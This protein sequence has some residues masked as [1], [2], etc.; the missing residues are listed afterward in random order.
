MY[1]L[2][3]VEDEFLIQYRIKNTIAWNT[4][5]F[6]VCATASDGQEAL[7][8]IK[9]R[10]PDV[11]VVLTDIK[12]PVMDGIEL[13]KVLKQNYPAVRVIILS[14]YSDFEYAQKAI[15][16]SAYSYVLK[17]IKEDEISALFS[18]LFSELEAS[19]T[20]AQAVSAPNSLRLDDSF[21]YMEPLLLK[22]LKS[23]GSVDEIRKKISGLEYPLHENSFC[24]LSFSCISGSG[25]ASHPPR[26]E[27][28]FSRA[29]YFWA[30]YSAPV[31]QNND[32]FHV[33][34][35]SDKTLYMNEIALRAKKFKA[36]MEREEGAGSSPDGIMVIGIGNVHTSLENMA[37]AC[38]E[39]VTA[40][41]YTFFK[42][43]GVI[44]QY[45]DIPQNKNLRPDSPELKESQ[46]RLFSAI[47][48]GE[49]VN[50]IPCVKKLFSS[51]LALG[52]TDANAF[53]MKCVSIYL[54]FSVKIEERNLPITFLTVDEIYNTLFQCKTLE[55]LTACYQERIY[56]L[57]LQ[58]DKLKS[59]EGNSVIIKIKQYIE[60]S[61]NKK[62]SLKELSEHFS[63]NA[64]YLS[65][66]FKDKTGEN[67][68]D[69]LL[70]VR[71]EKAKGL[72]KKTDKQIVEISEC[73][74]FTDYRYFCT[75]FKKVTGLTPLQYRLNS[76][77]Q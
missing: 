46:D 39:S 32:V 31:L 21:E 56:A 20:S 10:Y 27:S 55:E 50:V 41:N 40:L 75:I 54:Y 38:R 65:T 72:L 6:E 66:L 4:L 37:A 63:L 71:I 51:L 68:T 7:S 64:S 60:D 8:V 26:H 48:A 73:I 34:L 24:I 58:A 1:K 35:H 13:L 23:N 33:I 57:A 47:T 12:M 74:G 3:I 49:P 15:E 53:I 61:Y 29:R 76:I 43:K 5:G 18:R 44:L 19:K 25:S 77:I 52:F 28:V 62:L 14:C 70:S 36:F 11:H 9:S 42:E 22:L 69:Y 67:V 30:E 17:P 59:Q 45:R 2:V 16:Y